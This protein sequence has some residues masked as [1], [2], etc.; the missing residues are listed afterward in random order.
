MKLKFLL[1]ILFAVTIFS[2]NAQQEG[3]MK[4]DAHF[5][6]D[7]EYKIK[8]LSKQAATGGPEVRKKIDELEDRLVTLTKDTD[9]RYQHNGAEW[10]RE[11]EATRLEYKK[12]YGY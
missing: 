3:L 11:L 4:R 5:I 6:V 7:L 8:E 10:R 9:E 12:D 1:T 2:A